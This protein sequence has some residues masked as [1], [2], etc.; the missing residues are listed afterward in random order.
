MRYSI[1]ILL[2]TIFVAALS[3]AENAAAQGYVSDK[4]FPVVVDGKAGFIDRTGKV[5]LEPKFDGVSYFS[6]GLARVSVGRDTIITS[7]F[8]QG[9][10]D[11]SGEMVIRPEWD[12]A[13]HFSEG[14]AA[15][16][17]DQTK[18]KFE[19][20]GRTFYTS[21]SHTWY[22]WGLINKKGEMV[23]EPK[24][25]DVSVFRDGI[26][27]AEITIMS[28]RK[29]GFIDTN[30]EWVIPPKFDHASQFSEGLARVFVKGKYGYIDRSGNI[31]INPEYSSASDFSEGL[32]CVKLGGDVI[33]PKGMSSVRLNADYGFIDK[34]GKVVFNV[35]RSG[36]ESFSNGIARVEFGPGHRAIDRSGKF[37]FDASV[38]VWSDFCEGLAQVYL[39]GGEIG[40]IDTTGEIVIKKRF[41]RADD[42]YRGLSQV[43]ESYDFGAK[44][45]YIDK[46]G[47]VIWEPT[48]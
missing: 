13:S 20:H 5:V 38:D 23:I 7:G 37:L 16:G 15:V 31:V 19:L 25:S 32:A 45:G 3:V 36:C 18:Q 35:G 1:K 8:S 28:E 42:F 39:G 26:A 10:I 4:W 34:T 46:T 24:F 30:G 43:C 9:F 2:L 22:R 27:A 14:L 6:E 21:A 44:C 12:V 48:K 17:Y 11:E 33:K 29:M 41:G 40:F 47:T